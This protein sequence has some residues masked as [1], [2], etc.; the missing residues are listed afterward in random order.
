M[1]TGQNFRIG[2]S[3][4]PHLTNQIPWNEVDGINYN[5]KLNQNAHYGLIS[6]LALP[7]IKL[8][9]FLYKYVAKGTAEKNSTSYEFKNEFWFLGVGT[10]LYF[11]QDRISGYL[12]VDLTLASGIQ[13]TFDN[14]SAYIIKQ[15]NPRIGIDTGVGFD[16][17][18]NKLISLDLSG[19]YSLI[20][21]AGKEENEKSFSNI[22]LTLSVLFKFS[23]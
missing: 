2:L 11:V 3:Y 23:Q 13:N 18:V 15:I 7:K 19:K 1:V 6:K 5:I 22:V 8:Q 16:F 10:E 17:P 20:N 9:G 21:L 14:K 12:I 4:G